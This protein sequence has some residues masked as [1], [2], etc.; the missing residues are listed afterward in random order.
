M[1]A[2][3]Y[4]VVPAPAKGTKAK[5]VKTA[6]ARFAN[7]I[8]ILLNE[9]AAEGWEYQRAELLPSE[10]RSGLTGSTTNWRNVLIFRR[11]RP[12]AAEDAQSTAVA[13]LAAQISAQIAAHAT[14]PATSQRGDGAYADTEDNSDAA[15]VSAAPPAVTRPETATV[16]TLGPATT[17]AIAPPTAIAGDPEAPAGAIAVPGRGARAMMA[18][19]GVEELSPVSG[20]TAALK[21][22]ATLAATPKDAAAKPAPKAEP[23][24]TK[25][26]EPSKDPAEG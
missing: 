4:K 24:L 20:V 13:Q 7:S 10:E 18:D 1:Q 17:T 16:P 26:E 11:A 23:K 22:R 12:A 5:G 15:S 8:D 9:M 21:A 2:F 25:A 3:E 19:D 6:E 14:V